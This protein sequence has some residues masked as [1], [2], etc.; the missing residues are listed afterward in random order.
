MDENSRVE[1]GKVRKGGRYNEGKV[2][3][4]KGRQ[5]IGNRRTK[6]GNN[7]DHKLRRLMVN[8]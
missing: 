1:G 6:T 2:E 8:G 5:E 3:R 4:K 7:I